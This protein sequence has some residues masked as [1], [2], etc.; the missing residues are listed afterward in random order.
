M[1]CWGC[2]RIV[3]GD[4]CVLVRDKWDIYYI[5][6][7]GLRLFFFLFRNFLCLFRFI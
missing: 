7:E 5:E 2:V 3:E 1:K 6:G 4:G